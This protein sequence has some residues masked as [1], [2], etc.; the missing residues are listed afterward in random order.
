MGTRRVLEGY[1]QGAIRVLLGGHRGY[2][3]ATVRISGLGV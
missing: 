2:S 1:Y 3:K